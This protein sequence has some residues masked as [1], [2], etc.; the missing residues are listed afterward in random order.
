MTTIYALFEREI[1]PIFTPG[2]RLGRAEGLLAQLSSPFRKSE[3][4]QGLAALQTDHGAQLD[5]PNGELKDTPLE[6]KGR[7]LRVTFP[8]D[9]Q[10]EV[11]TRDLLAAVRGVIAVGA[12][13]SQLNS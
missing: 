9:V 2:G 6:G 3:E 13:I 4:V 10:A 12:N 1:S 7:V 5:L 8:S 11:V